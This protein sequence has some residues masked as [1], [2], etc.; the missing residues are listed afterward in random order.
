MSTVDWKHIQRAKQLHRESEAARPFAEKLKTLDR[1]RERGSQLKALRKQE[2]FA[3]TD[4]LFLMGA[5][6]ILLAAITQMPETESSQAQTILRPLE[7]V[8]P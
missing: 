8:T 5:D 3:G 1:M 4:R 6:P 2:C 7:P